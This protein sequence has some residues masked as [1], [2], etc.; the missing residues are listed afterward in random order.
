M[1]YLK[2]YLANGLFSWGDKLINEIIAKYMRQT[3]TDLDLY[4]PQENMAINDKNG[5]ADSLMIAKG[6]DEHL[7]ASDFLVAVIDGQD[8]DSGVA[9]EI[10]VFSATGKPIF[11]LF[12]DGR[13]DGTHNPLKISALQQDPVENQF[14]YRNLYV[15]GKIKSNGMITDNVVDLVMAIQDRFDLES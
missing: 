15:V 2:A 8:I 9:C 11:A 3:I 4:V 1:N 14:V 6:D 5:Y 12:T 10:G 7:L 13:Q